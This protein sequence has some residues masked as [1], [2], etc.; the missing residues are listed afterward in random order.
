[1]ILLYNGVKQDGLLYVMSLEYQ[2]LSN[3]ELMANGSGVK[4]NGTATT[5]SWR[6]SSWPL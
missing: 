4:R 3:K 6:C 2:V 1:M 5:P